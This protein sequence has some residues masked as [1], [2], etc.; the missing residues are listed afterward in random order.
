MNVYLCDFLSQRQ[1]KMLS[2]VRLVNIVEPCINSTEVANS[3]KSCDL[4]ADISNSPIVTFI[5]D[6]S[7]KLRVENASSSS[8]R[9][10]V[11]DALLM[12]NYV[13]SLLSVNLIICK[14]FYQ[15][16]Y[17]SISQPLYCVILVIAFFFSFF[18]FSAVNT[19]WAY[20]F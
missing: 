11:Y 18:K 7:V 3:T 10:S 15:L 2:C 17:F 1:K 14:M 4:P 6:L 13:T 5:Q 19:K 16:F 20:Y 8:F 12:P 9:K